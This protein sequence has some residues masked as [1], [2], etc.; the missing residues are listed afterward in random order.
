MTYQRI[1]HSTL[2]PQLNH[3]ETVTAWYLQ[4]GYLHEHGLGQNEVILVNLQLSK[5]SKRA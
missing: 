2:L 3:Q 4:V 5:P 1:I